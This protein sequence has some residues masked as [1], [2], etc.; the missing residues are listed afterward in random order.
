VAATRNEEKLAIDVYSRAESSGQ[1]IT[2]GIVERHLDEL[3]GHQP[4]CPCG[5]CAAAH[6]ARASGVFYVAN[7]WAAGIA[8]TR[9]RAAR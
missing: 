7:R 1:P 8:A 2:L 9:R 6:A 5:L 3:R 4:D